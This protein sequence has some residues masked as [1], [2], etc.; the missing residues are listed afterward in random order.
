ME[1]SK[2]QFI[3]LVHKAYP[4]VVMKPITSEEQT[5]LLWQVIRAIDSHPELVADPTVRHNLSRP[6]KKWLDELV[7]SKKLVGG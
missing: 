2:R 3:A 1:L 7:A 6:K 5:V 4:E